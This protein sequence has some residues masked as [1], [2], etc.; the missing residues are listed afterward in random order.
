MAT[1]AAFLLAQSGEFDFVLFGAAKA[2]AVIDSDTFVLAVGV[3]SLSMLMTPL[4]VWIGDTLAARVSDGALRICELPALSHR[5]LR[6]FVR[7]GWLGADEA[8]AMRDWHN[9]GGFSLDAGMRHSGV[10]PCRSGAAAALLRPP[11]ALERLEAVD[12]EHLRYHLSKPQPDG[13]T[14]VGPPSVAPSSLLRFA[15]RSCF[16]TE[17]GPRIHARSVRDAAKV[18]RT[19]GRLS[20][21]QV[22]R[23]AA[24]PLRFAFL[25]RSTVRGDPSC[26]A[27]KL[28]RA[29]AASSPDLPSQ[30]TH[31]PAY[32]AIAI[33][34]C[35]RPTRRCAPKSP[36]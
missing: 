6:W 12:D 23:R 30:L 2:L 28:L 10:G 11:F 7:R 20:P 17:P 29:L 8:R 25:L 36:P 27:R 14:F 16:A 19:F 32:T 21:R 3:I 34:A 22:V 4:L 9:D 35:W 5:V 15:T 24:T 26:I 33:T 31:R 18:H 13:T 1:R